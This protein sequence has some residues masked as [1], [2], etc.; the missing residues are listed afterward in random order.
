[1]DNKQ[2]HLGMIQGVVNR[3]SHNS[4]LLKGWS[5]VLVSAMFA[6]AA[7]DSKMVFIYLAYFPA[8]SF[9]G[10]DGYF[11]RQER[12]FRALYDHVRKLDEKDIDFSMN[13]SIVEPKV[14]P[15]A[16]V[17][18]S[19]TLLVFHGVIFV[20]IILVMCFVIIFIK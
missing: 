20:S 10:L 11:L 8:I 15:W 18:L 6:F 7:K 16:I 4:F 3:L 9:W 17:T 14:A 5:V 19:K 1:M 2:S 13:T 12:L